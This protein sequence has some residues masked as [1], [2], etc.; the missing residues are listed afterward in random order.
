MWPPIYSPPWPPWESKTFLG[1][2]WHL[3]KLKFD[4]IS[5]KIPRMQI[6][7]KLAPLPLTV[8]PDYS[9]PWPAWGSKIFLGCFWHLSKLKFDEISPKIPT[10]Q[11]FR[12]L[13]PSQLYPLITHPP[14]PLGSQKIFW[15]VFGIYLSSS[16]KK[17]HQKYHECGV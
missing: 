6:L 13:A 17:Y 16:F 5:P 7:R 9:P 2:F 10:M 11:I 15:V 12:K 8:P 14:G 1:C 3:S 4:K